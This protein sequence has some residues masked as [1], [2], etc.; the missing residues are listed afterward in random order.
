ME[1]KRAWRFGTVVERVPPTGF[2][3]TAAGFHRSR[4]ASPLSS[5]E[6]NRGALS[7]ALRRPTVD[8][9]SG[10]AVSSRYHA[11]IV[12]AHGHSCDFDRQLLPATCPPCTMR[13]AEP[14]HPEI[15]GYFTFLL[16]SVAPDST[17]K[18]CRRPE[19][20][21]MDGQRRCAQG[22]GGVVPRQSKGALARTREDNW[23]CRRVTA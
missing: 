13:D 11:H 23:A 1:I 17:T 6:P 7:E 22:S 8:A 21:G 20:D 5:L 9:A 4:N 15:A 12:N 18:W 14:Q 3:P 19:M 10:A 2:G 16:F